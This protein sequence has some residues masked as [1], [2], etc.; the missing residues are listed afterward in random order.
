MYLENYLEQHEEVKKEMD[1]I[2]ALLAFND[3]AEHA[4]E[5]ASH[6]NTLAGKISMHLLMEDKHLYPNLIERGNDEVKRMAE[7]FQKEMGNLA[8]VFVGY[9]ERYNTSKKIIQNINSI[10]SDTN[11]VFSKIE[12]R[13][14]KEENELY[15][16]I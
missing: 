11:E 14:I 6:M 13:I 7:R 10:K 1:A 3:I 2:K 4:K 15:K 9:K 5:I 8:E 16:H 12:K